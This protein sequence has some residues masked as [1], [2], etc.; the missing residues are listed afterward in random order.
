MSFRDHLL[1]EIAQLIARVAEEGRALEPRWITHEICNAHQSGLARG[2]EADFWMHHGHR[3]VRAD[4]G[5][6]IRKHFNPEADADDAQN[7]LPGFE[8]VQTHYIVERD[9]Q[10]IG[11]PTPQMTDDEI[12]ATVSRM[13]S[14][15]ATLYAHADEL[16]RYRMERQHVA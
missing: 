16:E 14:S 9:G 3:A 10:E 8:H 7:T 13:R 1:E 6:Y 11:I 15:A 4:V 12:E 2:E 5:N